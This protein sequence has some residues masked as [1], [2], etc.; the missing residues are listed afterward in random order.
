MVRRRNG[1]R[2][3]D[4]LA[5]TVERS[6]AHALPTTGE[7]AAAADERRERTRLSRRDD[8]HRPRLS[9]RRYTARKRNQDRNSEN[10][11]T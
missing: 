5:L 1:R 11:V 7:Q 10:G 3:V 2:R 6:H 8:E 9:G 4:E